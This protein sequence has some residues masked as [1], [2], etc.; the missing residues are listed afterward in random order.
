MVKESL[1][2][3]VK[4]FSSDYL[5]DEEQLYTTVFQQN[6]GNFNHK[7]KNVYAIFEFS[8]HCLHS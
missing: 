7:F 2:V 8:F 3:H 4:M 6:N 5:F 1:D